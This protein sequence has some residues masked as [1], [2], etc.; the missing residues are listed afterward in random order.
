M[1]IISIWQLAC[2]GAFYS[3]AH[4]LVSAWLQMRLDRSAVRYFRNPQSIFDAKHCAKRA[5]QTLFRRGA[6]SNASHSE[7]AMLQF[8]I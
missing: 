4:N 6:N 1:R 7:P 3:S 5:A 2:L 8:S